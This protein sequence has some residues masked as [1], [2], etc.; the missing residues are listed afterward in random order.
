M[1]ALPDASAPGTA[2]WTEALHMGRF[3]WPSGTW[4]YKPGLRTDLHETLG[5]LLVFG[6]ITCSVLIPHLILGSSAELTQITNYYS[7]IFFSFLP[8]GP[9][10]S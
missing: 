2:P 3:A 4:S 5:S 9:Q 1:A 8:P 7:T 10:L 6:R